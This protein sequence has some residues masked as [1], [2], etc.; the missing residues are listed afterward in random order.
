MPNTH[1]NANTKAGIGATT[2]TGGHWSRRLAPRSLTDRA[3]RAP[4]TPQLTAELWSRATDRDRWLLRMLAEHRVLT[5]THITSDRIA[6]ARL[7]MLAN[8]R[9]ITGLRPRGGPGSQP[10]HWALDEAGARLLAA[11]DGTDLRTFGWRRDHALAPLAAATLTHTV[12]VNNLGIALIAHTRTHPHTRLRAWWGQRRTADAVGDRVQPDGYYH[13]TDGA[14]HVEFFLEYDTGTEPHKTLL[15][16]ADRYAALAEHTPLDLPV[17]FVLPN[18][19]REAT[20]RRALTDAPALIA[21]TTPHALQA[22][23]GP[24]GPAWQPL[25]HS[26]PR[27]PPTCLRP[28]TPTPPLHTHLPPTARPP[29]DPVSYK[30]MTR[31]T[32]KRV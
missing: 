31:P 3:G 24:A 32:I 7:Q 14:H 13:W 12:G 6:R 10:W 9:A 4:I 21:T 15:A 2:R 18:P 17:L 16:K 29:P 5:T 11:D 30:Q 8:F 26:G 22:A 20:L 27:Q 23:G 1:N 25:P 19:A 28:R